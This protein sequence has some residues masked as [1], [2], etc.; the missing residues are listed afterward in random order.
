MGSSVRTRGSI[1]RQDGSST[2]HSKYHVHWYIY[3][4]L[5][6]LEVLTDFICISRDKLDV[7]YMTEFDPTWND[8]KWAAVIDPEAIIFANPL[9]QLACIGDCALSSNQTPTNKLF[10]CAGCEGSLYPFSGTVAHHVGGIQASS[11]LVNRIIAKFHRCSMLKGFSK[12]DFCEARYIPIIKK[13]LYKTQL[14]F[15]I[16]QTKTECNALGRSDAIWGSGKSFPSG[17]ED[18]VYLVWTKRHCCLDALKP[19]MGAIGK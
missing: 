16:A 8:D 6:V 10:W 2:K 9:A 7:A 14:L 19:A 17:G 1:G 11:L 15:P 18:F 13:T 12:E 5:A 3:P 4:V